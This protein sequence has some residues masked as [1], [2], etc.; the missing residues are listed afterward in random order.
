MADVTY[1][2]TGNQV[3]ANLRKQMRKRTGLAEERPN[4]LF[5]LDTGTRTLGASSG[6]NT[7]GDEITLLN[8]PSQLPCIVVGVSVTLNEWDDGTDALTWDLVA[9]NSAGTEEILLNEAVGGRVAGVTHW[10]GCS[11]DIKGGKLILEIAEP[12]AS[13][14]ASATLR[15]RIAL[16]VGSTGAVS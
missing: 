9:E 5:I 4:G 1:S 12:S 10:G 3:Y 7:A 16:L 13:E 8:L 11:Q 15:T 6:F 2:L 14:V